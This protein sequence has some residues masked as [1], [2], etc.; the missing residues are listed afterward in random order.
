MSKLPQLVLKAP[1]RSNFDLSYVNRFTATAGALYPIMVQRCLPGDHF[2]IS[3]SHL[4]KTMA[5]KAPLMGRMSLIF[6]FFFVPDRLYVPQFRQN[7]ANVQS[8][9]DNMSDVHMPFFNLPLQG[10]GNGGPASNLGPLSAGHI[11]DFLGIPAGFKDLHSKITQDD[12]TYGQESVKFNALPLL[13][14]YD[15]F[16]NYYRNPQEGTAYMFSRSAGTSQTLDPSIRGFS[17]EALDTVFE[18]IVSGKY[19]N[20]TPNPMQGPYDP[21]AGLHFWDLMLDELSTQVPLA[22]LCLRTY[23]PDYFSNFINTTFYDRMNLGNFGGTV[24]VVNGKFSIQQFRLAN[25]LQKLSERA[26]IAGSRYG[27]FIRAMFGVNTDDKLDIPEYMGRFSTVMTFQDIVSQTG[28]TSEYDPTQG[29]YPLGSSAGRGIKA[30][31]SKKFYINATEYGNLFCIFSIVPSP[32]YFEGIK[33]ELTKVYLSDEFN[34][35]LDRVGW[36]PMTRSEIYALPTTDDMGNPT[37]DWSA[38]TTAD[39]FDAVVGYHP[40]WLE[41]MTRTNELHGEFAT[42]LNFWTIGRTFDRSLETWTA[43]SDIVPSA[44]IFPNDYAVP[45]VDDRLDAQNF[46]V[47]VA[48]DIF[49]RRPISKKLMPNLG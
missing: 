25:K 29:Q 21:L 11:L 7:N 34:P 6:D 19:L 10:P 8:F 20:L 30:D 17:C 44:Y 26:I 23:Q 13:G 1:K 39:P 33:K 37:V 16:R 43:T 18:G 2:E 31:S 35:Q 9:A 40:A 22:G 47:Q 5:L 4:V 38:T 36:Q 41:Y 27:E 46:M 32:D 3:L 42:S 14:Y 48:F 49:A 28:N 45:F 15:I 12:N 24:D